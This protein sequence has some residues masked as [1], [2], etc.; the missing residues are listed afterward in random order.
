M[1][2]ASDESVAEEQGGESR[3]QR[4]IIVAAV[5]A[6]LLPFLVAPIPPLTD[7]PGHLA[8]FAIAEAPASSPLHGYFDVRWIFTPNLGVDLIVA[9]LA[10]LIGVQAAVWL[11]AAAIPV[12]TAAALAMI[13]RTRNPGAAA[14]LPWALVFVFSAP[15]LWGFLNYALA[16]ALALL[17]FA[18]WLR[19]GGATRT[20][21]AIMAPPLLF[22]V[23]AIGG[24]V[25]PALVAGH[26]AWGTPWRE[27]PLALVR[28][29]A[30]LALST[31]ATLLVWRLFGASA[32]GGAVWN[33]GR[34]LT[35]LVQ[36]L[37]D[38]D[39][40]FDIATVALA[41][42]VFGYGIAKGAR[43][44]GGAGPALA[45]LAFYL[46][47]PTRI[48]ATDMIDVRV[49][50]LLPMAAL[51]LQDWSA[52]PARTR[53]RVFW[54]GIA[55]LV[56]RLAVT[57]VSFAGYSSR[58]AEELAA[59]DHV[60]RGAR[61]LN[62]TVTN[63]P[64]RAWRQLRI[65]HLA[66]LASPRREAWI[67]AHWALEGVH[68]L[69]VR[70]RPSESFFRDPSHIVWED[71]CV[72]ERVPAAGRSRHTLAETLPLLPI[73]GADRLW[74]IGGDLPRGYRDSRLAL[75]WRGRDSALYAVR[76]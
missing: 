71:R 32:A 37:R 13:A 35:G 18:F 29:L 15:L 70:Y 59:L 38:Q 33:P 34:K 61:I 12:T 41:L 75:V 10:P 56:V 2:G 72:D 60:P 27:R 26:V 23:H 9:G 66:N 22:V 42:A 11:A 1:A 20:A 50:P 65:E 6:M 45:L 36:M 44:R 7:L 47:L 21:L 68:T 55:L 25:F 24:L 51:A 46:I 3:L 28:N 76:R 64:E 69:G 49:A 63:C 16:V 54:G 39:M 19:G 30:P 73:D 31:G 58:Y 14:A 74:L 43:L 5:F 57:L 17:A 62:L 48:G 4:R 8:R 53:A 67:N 52:V 40:V